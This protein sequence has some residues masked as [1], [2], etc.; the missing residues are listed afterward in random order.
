MLLNYRVLSRNSR[1]STLVSK[2]RD[3]GG[4]YILIPVPDGTSV[5]KQKSMTC[6]N[7]ST[8][9][10]VLW[11]LLLCNTVKLKSTISET[12]KYFLLI[13]LLSI[14]VCVC[15]CVP[16]ID[17]PIIDIILNP[18]FFQNVH[19]CNSNYSGCRDQEDHSSKPAVGKL[20][21]RPYLKKKHHKKGLAERLKW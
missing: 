5:G 1:V 13:F 15:V 21:M 7:L 19:T 18:T 11:T 20:F 3:K 9:W 17:V 4:C 6:N 8:F 12:L 16:N 2:A 10:K 14:F